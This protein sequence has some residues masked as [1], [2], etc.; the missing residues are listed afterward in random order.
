MPDELEQAR[1]Y[2]DLAR[3]LA[4]RRVVFRSFDMG[5]DR[6]HGLSG[7]EPPNPALGL[8]ALRLGLS[9][10]ELFKAQLRAML[11]ASVRGN[12]HIMFPLVSSLGELRAARAVLDAARNELAAEGVPMGPVRVGCMIEVPSAALVAH[13]LAAEC[14]FFSVGTNDLVQ[15]TLAVDRSD[16][17]VAH[18]ASPLHPAV[19]QLLAMTARAAEACGI[20]C[21]MCGGMAADPVALPLVLGLGFGRLSVDLGGLP[22]ARAC[23]ERVDLEL[24]RS[25][26]QRALACGTAE[27]VRELV[28]QTFQS[29]LRELW[30]EHGV[31][32]L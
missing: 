16:P 3:V 20:E 32:A 6:L 13:A 9:L 1:V 5:G 11:R 21:S 31:L 19:L 15:Y 12:V 14:D 24:A 23:I 30:E 8:R 7:A 29:D 4:P 26:A 10:P 27:E 17:R 28:V 25:V 22:I 2:D 18:L